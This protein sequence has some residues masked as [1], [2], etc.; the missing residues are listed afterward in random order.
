MS[1]QEP[2]LATAAHEK[3]NAGKVIMEH[4]SNTA[5]Q[6]PLIHLPKIFGIDF[7]VTKHVLMLWL[8]AAFV[9]IVVTWTVRRVLKQESRVPTGV[10]NALEAVVEF[11][12]DTIVLPNVGSKWVNTWAPLI[13]T[14]FFFILA[15]NTAGL[16]P[17]F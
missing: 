15:A 12:R 1:A 5:L 4:V 9:F 10:M 2:E 11:I 8:G 16:I 3:F 17:V 13:L 7:S 14:F 6:H